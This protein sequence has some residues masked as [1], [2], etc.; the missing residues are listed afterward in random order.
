VDFV[1][2]SATL[3][4]QLVGERTRRKSPA[5]R[6]AAA[7]RFFDEAPVVFAAN[8]PGAAQLDSLGRSSMAVQ[9][10]RAH[11]VHQPFR[12]G[13]DKASAV[14]AL[15]RFKSPDG[16]TGFR[17]LRRSA[18]IILGGERRANYHSNEN[19]GQNTL[20]PWASGPAEILRHGLSLLKHDTDTNRRL[21]MISIDNAVELMVKTYLGLPKRVTGLSISRKEYADFSESF[22]AL[23]DALER[24]A[25]DKLDGIDLG[26]IE[27][28][29]RLRNQLYHQGNGLTVERD[30]AEIYAE[31][32]NVLFKNLFGVRLVPHATER[33]DLLGQF[34]E[35]WVA[36]ERGFQAL[37]RRDGRRYDPKSSNLF[38]DVEVNEIY[39]YREIRNQV[40]HGHKDHRSLITPEII[41]RLSGFVARLA[42]EGV[43][44]GT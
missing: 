1:N 21:A 32:A 18:I 44:G 2:S 5:Y 4:N 17:A 26:T 8:V 15:T 35:Q 39:R 23:L 25:S 16:I 40:L 19:M 36:L 10:F 38:S 41:R 3:F 42:A 37:G 27:W 6:V 34:I 24:K 9:L 7:K 33:T 31:L 22:P 14:R 30:K 43:P 12:R 11:A 20:L 28:Y 13:A 29:H